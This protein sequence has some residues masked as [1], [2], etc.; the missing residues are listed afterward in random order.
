[1]RQLK[2]NRNRRNDRR[3][4]SVAIA[5]AIC[6][7]WAFAGGVEVPCATGAPAGALYCA[8]TIVPASGDRDGDG[9]LDT[10]EAWL[11]TNPDVADTDGDGMADG[12]ELTADTLPT[13]R[14]S[15]LRILSVEA[16]ADG[17]SLEWQGGRSARQLLEICSA[18]P[19]SWSPIHTNEP[20]TAWVTNFFDP[21]LNG[22]TRFY[23]IRID[24][25]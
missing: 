13:E 15:V 10:T 23:R 21:G 3:R 6:V 4:R 24:G 9:L 17:T 2:T 11:G 20:P 22:R 25:Q 14:T 16:D 19:S 1:M 5:V 18:L 7:F 12:D 8:V